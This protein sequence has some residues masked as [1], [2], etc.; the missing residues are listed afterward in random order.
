ME[1]D[2]EATY[3]RLKSQADILAPEAASAQ[4]TGDSVLR[5]KIL[6]YWWLPYVAIPVFI[7]LVMWVM[8]PEIV[9]DKEVDE[10]NVEHLSLNYNRLLVLSMIISGA[11]IGVWWYFTKRV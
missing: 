7:F 11:L 8:S 1:K 9:M 6:D 3:Q 10:K 4:P 2:Y 5:F